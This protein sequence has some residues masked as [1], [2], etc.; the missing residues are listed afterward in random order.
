MPLVVTVSGSP[1]APSRTSQLNDW[2][3]A[4]IATQGFD[5]ARINVRDLPPA[6]VLHA[7][8]ES[9][10]LRE[11]LGL[12]ER[13]QGVVVATPVYKASYTGV[14]KSFLD[15]LP[16]FGLSGKV[17]LPLATG[18][19]IA[20][21]LAIDYGLRPVLSALGAQHVVSGLFILDKQLGPAGAVPLALEPEIDTRLRSV[22]G[23]FVTSLRR[24]Q[25]T[26]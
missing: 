1:L 9:P 8:L 5:V 23:D 22:V 15:L 19:T 11:P 25:V 21:V 13:A 14:L 16:Q 2:V 17:I 7:R 6:D 12:I 18:G 26:G 10:A 24:Q 4:Q 20:H 3:A